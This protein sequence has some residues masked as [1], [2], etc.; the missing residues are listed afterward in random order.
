MVQSWSLRSTAEDNNLRWRALGSSAQETRRIRREES[1]VSDADRATKLERSGAR[2][3]SPPKCLQYCG[4]SH[5]AMATTSNGINP[6][7]RTSPCPLSTLSLSVRILLSCAGASLHHATT[8]WSTAFIAGHCTSTNLVSNLC[9]RLV[10][11]SVCSLA[12]H[13]AF[14]VANK[15]HSKFHLDTTSISCDC[16]CWSLT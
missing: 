15:R 5:M 11:D 12:Y 16:S 7:H 10:F 9:A 14:V 6:Q 2:I 13:V 1:E 3:A 8:R 4:E